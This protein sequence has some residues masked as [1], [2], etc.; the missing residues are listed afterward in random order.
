MVLIDTDGWNMIKIMDD[1]DG[2]S[3]DDFTIIS[4]RLLKLMKVKSILYA[5]MPLN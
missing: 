5:I 4:F 2:S 1:S 3:M